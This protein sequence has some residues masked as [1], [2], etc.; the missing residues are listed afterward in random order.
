MKTYLNTLLLTLIGLTM[1]A[2][3]PARAMENKQSSKQADSNQDSFVELYQIIVDRKN[4]RAATDAANEIFKGKSNDEIKTLLTKKRSFS[5]RNL[6]QEARNAGATNFA[7]FLKEK[8]EAVSI[9]P[10]SQPQPGA[11]H[12]ANTSQTAIEQTVQPQPSQ[13]QEESQQTTVQMTRDEVF[14]QALRTNPE[15][16]KTI[17]RILWKKFDICNLRRAIMDFQQHENTAIIEWMYK[18]TDRNLSTPTA[19]ES[20][21]QCAIRHNAE[22]SG[23]IKLVECL[24]N[25]IKD[26]KESLL[27]QNSGK[28]TALHTVVLNIPDEQVAVLVATLILNSAGSEAIKLL[29]IKNKFGNTAYKEAQLWDKLELAK[30]LADKQKA[31]EIKP[32]DNETENK[33]EDPTNNNQ[34]ETNPQIKISS[35]WSAYLQPRYIFGTLSVCVCAVAAAVAIYYFWQGHNNIPTEQA[36]TEI[37]EEL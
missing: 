20:Y 8:L 32:L 35:W 17:S 29:D 21:L 7:Q 12:L 31:K 37:M 33:Q 30:F 25:C 6:E 14:A 11:D 18:Y 1:L 15:D 34:K 27:R 4:Y 13:P 19:G 2:A 22:K 5:Q 24:L 36:T 26:S 28:G 9:A 23:L 3:I 16:I 10:Q